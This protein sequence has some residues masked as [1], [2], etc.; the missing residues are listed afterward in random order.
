MHRAGRSCS[1][2]SPLQWVRQVCGAGCSRQAGSSFGQL[3][4]PIPNTL[5]AQGLTPAGDSMAGVTAA[6]A[7]AASSSSAGSSTWAYEGFGGHP[8]VMQPAERALV[9][10]VQAV[11]VL[12]E[13]QLPPEV[14]DGGCVARCAHARAG[15]PPLQPLLPAL[16]VHMCAGL[17]PAPRTN[18][19]SHLASCC[20]RPAS[21]EPL[22]PP[23]ECPCACHPT[24]GIRTL[25]A[26]LN[27]LGTAW[28][29][30]A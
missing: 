6:A 4:S 8:A 2:P 20:S 22:C 3:L 14:V 13:Q 16:C 7:A 9:D 11:A 25:S 21:S 27:S 19:R 29:S 26:S 12:V 17:S 23:H 10:S 30:G 15:Q 18:Y 5:M 28:S 24:L 1:D